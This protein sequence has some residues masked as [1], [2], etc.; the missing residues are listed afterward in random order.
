MTGKQL[1]FIS[2]DS[3]IFEPEDLWEKPLAAK[4][5][6]QVPRMVKRH[7]GVEGKFFFSGLEYIRQDEAVEGDAEMQAKLLRASYDPAERMKCLD[8]DNIYGEIVNST[9]LLFGMRAKNDDLV[10]D[11][12][13]VFNDWLSEYCSH[14]PKRLFG[15][16]MIHMEDPIWAAKE[17]ERVAKRGL[18]SAIINCDTRPHWEPYQSRKYDPFWAAAQALDMPVTLHII[19]GNERDLFTLHGPERINIPRSALGVLGEAGAVLANEFIFGGIMDR[20][21]KLKLVCSEFEVSWLPYWFFRVRQIEQDFGPVLKFPKI[22]RPVEEYL[23]RIYHGMIDDVYIEKVLDVVP[24]STL[25]WGSDFPHA[26]CTYPETAKV[27]DRIFGNLDPAT[28][29]AVTFANAAKL[30]NFDVPAEIAA[31]AAAAAA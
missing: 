8:E 1:L 20:F 13:A 31:A 19:T 29:H 5:G 18:K 12:C 23:P 6:D 10:R 16:A 3:H 14:A 28:R 17:L 30:Y 22:A 4:Y 15:T 21:P 24:L 2:G 9:F 26:R 11:C 27:I 25:M 7:M